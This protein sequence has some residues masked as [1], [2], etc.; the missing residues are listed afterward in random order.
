MARNDRLNYESD[1][2]GNTSR[3]LELPSLGGP[4][5]PRSSIISIKRAARVYPMR[6]TPLQERN[7]RFFQPPHHIDRRLI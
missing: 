1:R 7:R 2:C 4:T 6:K 5:T 3:G